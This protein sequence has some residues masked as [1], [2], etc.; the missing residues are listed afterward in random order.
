[1]WWQAAKYVRVV[2]LLHTSKESIAG[3]IFYSS[4][5]IT[6]IRNSTPNQV[7]LVNNNILTDPRI[8]KYVRIERVKGSENIIYND[9]IFRDPVNE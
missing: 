2:I 9:L 1:M 5:I 6:E 3:E 7:R 8:K 4:I